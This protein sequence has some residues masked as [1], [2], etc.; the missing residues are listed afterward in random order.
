M[1]AVPDQRNAHRD[2]HIPRRYLQE[3]SVGFPPPASVVNSPLAM[4]VS[5]A[6]GKK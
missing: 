4:E 2:P 6:N 5:E 3:A 1:I